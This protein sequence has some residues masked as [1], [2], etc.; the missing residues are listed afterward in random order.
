MISQYINKA[1]GCF[2]VAY[3]LKYSEKE[4]VEHHLDWLKGIRDATERKKE[5]KKLYK[6]A[7]KIGK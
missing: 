3:V 6:E 4:F 5:L 2:R 7:E 1:Y